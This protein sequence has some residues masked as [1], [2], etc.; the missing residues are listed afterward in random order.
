MVQAVIFLLA[1]LQP[2]LADFELAGAA[3]VRLS[4][5]CTQGQLPHSCCPLSWPL[6]LAAALA[7]PAVHAAAVQQQS[8]DM[9]RGWLLTLLPSLYHAVTLQ[10]PAEDNAGDRDTTCPSLPRPQLIP[11]MKASAPVAI[12]L[13]RDHRSLLGGVIYKESSTELEFVQAVVNFLGF[14][15]SWHICD[16]SCGRAIGGSSSN[17]GTCD[18]GIKH[19]TGVSDSGCLTSCS[20][21][22]RQP[23]LA[24]L[25]TP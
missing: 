12:H 4:L 19:G 7:V 18:L 10:Y 16:S 5:V 15:L 14:R 1:L 23:V 13:L 6:L 9:K 11:L 2:P 17:G 20:C 8:P 3:L 25:V 21:A 24:A 22:D